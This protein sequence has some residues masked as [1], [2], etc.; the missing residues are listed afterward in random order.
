MTAAKHEVYQLPNKHS[1]V[2]YLFD[3]LE[4]SNVGLNATMASV[5]TDDT[6]NR[7]RNNFEVVVT[8]L[9]PYNPVVKKRTKSKSRRNHVKIS[10]A[11]AGKGWV[12]AF[13]SKKGIGNTGVHLQH[14]KVL[15]YKA[16]TQEQQDELCK[17]RKTPEGAK[18]MAE[19]K[20][21]AGVED[22][23]HSKNRHGSKKARFQSH[24]KILAAIAE[25][26]AKHHKAMLS[27]LEE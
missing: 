23:K 18:A 6:A 17:W 5:K 12:A 10:A 21:A 26:I 3:F 15:A 22:N 24:K 27:D 2:G 8:H 16:L 20:K 11:D 1:R 19:S 14:H 4:S 25:G 7:K 13:G 9:L